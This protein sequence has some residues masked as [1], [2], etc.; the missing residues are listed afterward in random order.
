MTLMELFQPFV[1]RWFEANF[2]EP[3]RVQ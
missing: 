2:S 3:T 1:R